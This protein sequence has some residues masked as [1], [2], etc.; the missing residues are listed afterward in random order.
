M[1]F[2]T[3]KRTLPISIPILVWC[4]AAMAESD[5]DLHKQYDEMLKRQDYRGVVTV[6][7]KAIALNP[8]DAAI[9]DRRAIAYTMLLF[10]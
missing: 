3:L 10:T 2:Q 6:L 8:K 1:L 4:G 9:Y 5:S 7:S